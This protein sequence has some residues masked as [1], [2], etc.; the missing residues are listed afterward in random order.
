[1][2]RSE[3]RRHLNSAKELNPTCRSDYFAAVLYRSLL[4]PQTLFFSHGQKLHQGKFIVIQKWKRSLLFSVKLT[5]VIESLAFMVPLIVFDC[6]LINYELLNFI[7]T[8]FNCLAIA[9]FLASFFF[10]NFKMTGLMVEPKLNSVIK[11]I[12][13][14][15]V[16][17]LVS[18]ILMV[19]VEL[20]IAFKIHDGSFE[21]FM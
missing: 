11:K 18:R 9:I 19:A 21:S 2:G 8:V 14:V 6:K 20:T 10:L 7:S 17:I 16:I 3:R 15:L 5:V 13:K 12:Y 1:M 4:L